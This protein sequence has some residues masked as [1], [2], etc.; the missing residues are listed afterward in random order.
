MKTIFEPPKPAPAP[1]AHPLCALDAKALRESLERLIKRTLAY[2]ESQSARGL[3]PPDLLELV[4]DDLRKRFASK[5][6]P[7]AEIRKVLNAIC[8]DRANDV[9]HALY[10][11]HVLR[12]GAT[13]NFILREDKH[14]PQGYQGLIPDS[15]GVL[16][17]ADPM[18]F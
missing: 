7:A 9:G 4:L 5:K 12:L 2:A 16:P 14:R 1:Q 11:A 15:N 3:S 18:P 17:D 8:G 10:P 13:S 6:I